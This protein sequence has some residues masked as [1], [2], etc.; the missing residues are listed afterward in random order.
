M[1]RLQAQ[2]E[3]YPSFSVLIETNHKAGRRPEHADFVVRV[4]DIE[5]MPAGMTGQRLRFGLPRE[6]LTEGMLQFSVQNAA[7]ETF[8]IGNLSLYAY[9]QIGGLYDPDGVD[10]PMSGLIRKFNS[11]VSKTSPL[12]H[13]GAATAWHQVRQRKWR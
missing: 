6:A 7:S 10:L 1:L 5:A 11:D 13:T 3:R 4:G 8:E 9:E 2:L 12:D